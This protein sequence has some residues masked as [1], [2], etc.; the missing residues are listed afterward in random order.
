M[1][2]V[3][4]KTLVVGCA[5]FAIGVLGRLITLG[6]GPSSNPTL[7]GHVVKVSWISSEHKRGDFI[8][9]KSNIFERNFLTKR[10]IGFPGETIYTPDIRGAIYPENVF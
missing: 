9:T 2:N 7:Y 8:D 1:K 6:S 5:V 10:I 3:L 4:Y